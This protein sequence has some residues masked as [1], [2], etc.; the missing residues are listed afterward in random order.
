VSK[1]LGLGVL[2][3]GVGALG[4]Y[5][6]AYDAGEIQTIITERAAAAATG[7]VHGVLSEV[8]GR[9][10]RLTGMAD[11][12]AERAALFAAADAVDGRRVVI[13]ELTVLPAA[14]PYTAGA[15]KADET[16]ALVG[17]GVVPSEAARAELAAVGW[18]DAA[19]ALT[20]ASGAPE[21]WMALAKAGVNALGPLISGEMTVTDAA[22][23]ITGTAL[24]P[25]EF[26]AMQAALA[27]LPEG[28][29]TLDVQTLDDGTPAAFDVDYEPVGGATIRGKLPVGLDKAMV[30]DALSL[31]GLTGDVVQGLIGEPMEIG[32]FASLS[33]WLPDLERLRIS[34]S[35]TGTQVVAEVARAADL[36]TVQAGLAQDLGPDVALDISVA[37]PNGTDGDERVNI[38]TGQAQRYG[39]GYWLPIPEFTF[40]RPT[41]QAET[42][43]VLDGAPITFVTGSDVLDA[44][45][46]T[47]LNNLASVMAECAR[48]SGMRAIIGGHTDSSGDEEANLG[49][50]QKRATAVRFV[51]IAR[52]VPA[53]ALRAIGFG[54]ALPIADNETA[55]GKARNRRTS[56]EWVE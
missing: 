10:I 43:K 45:A 30:G 5:G 34:A 33:S 7:S 20:L 4:L 26:D 15:V 29:V 9:D 53:E 55:E 19:T 2:I 8:S 17:K 13:D 51:L 41:C 49:L 47:V 40:D 11:T 27:G 22:L 39:G 6:R 12:E 48:A 44:S 35:P 21:G 1:L 3:L 56:V 37:G 50:S 38:A 42:Q 14:T 46:K 16:A 25:V 52:G 54:E 36:A 28:A 31:P 24:S 23:T 32:V 18:G